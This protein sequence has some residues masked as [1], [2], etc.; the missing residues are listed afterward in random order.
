[1]TQLLVIGYCSFQNQLNFIFWY[2]VCVQDLMPEEFWVARFICIL[3]NPAFTLKSSEPCGVRRRES[4]TLALHTCTSCVFLLQISQRR[5]LIDGTSMEM[6]WAMPW[7]H[8]L[9]LPWPL[10]ISPLCL[11]V[12]GEVYV[13]GRFASNWFCEVFFETQLAGTQQ[14]QKSNTQLF[15]Q[16]APFIELLNQ[17]IFFYFLLNIVF[18]IFMWTVIC[19][20]SNYFPHPPPPPKLSDSK[21]APV[22]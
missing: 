12:L 14:Q 5:R 11:T 19:W 16:L 4:L 17:Y 7:L 10:K 6:G 3:E 13:T 1:M 21:K 18:F 8:F 2:F 9:A 15:E 20:Q 22:F